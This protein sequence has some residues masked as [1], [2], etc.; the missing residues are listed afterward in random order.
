[1][2]K[3]RSFTV[4]IITFVIVAL[5]LYQLQVFL[6][7]MLSIKS[8][9]PTIVKKTAC[10]ECKKNDNKVC[11]NNVCIC[12]KGYVWLD[13]K[14]TICGI[15]KPPIKSIVTVTHTDETQPI[16]I[17]TTITQEIDYKTL[18]IVL[19]FQLR[20]EA[21][22]NDNPKLRLEVVRSSDKKT[23]F[24]KLCNV[25]DG[26][27]RVVVPKSKFVDGNYNTFYIATL[28]YGAENIAHTDFKI[29][30]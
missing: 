4:A 9:I 26:H 21:F 19:N 12:K 23:V 17:K 2:H 30:K 27:N 18:D 6:E 20:K 16:R 24:A 14:H 25:Q 8:I 15:L 3:L 22:P 5:L 13:K 11:V 1:M 10:E 7:R 29:I 28:Y